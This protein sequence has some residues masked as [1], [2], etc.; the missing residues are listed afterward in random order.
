MSS[1]I[2][3]YGALGIDSSGKSISEISIA[4]SSPM[5]E[6][7]RGKV[8][9]VLIAGLAEKG[10]PRRITELMEAGGRRELD[11]ECVLVLV[12]VGTGSWEGP[13]KR[14]SNRELAVMSPRL[15]PR[16]RTRR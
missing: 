2:I 4:G 12:V 16:L 10:E 7:L 6:K 5:R 11:R 1:Q 15:N 13:A 14:L 8:L 9:N 3:D